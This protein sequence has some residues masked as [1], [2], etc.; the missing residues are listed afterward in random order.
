MVQAEKIAI[1]DIGSNSVRIRISQGEEVFFRKVITTQ[2]ARGK[3][4]GKLDKK[5]V[6]R[7]FD[8]LDRLFEKANECGAKVLAFATAAVRNSCQAKEFC[9][10]F[11]ERYGVAL[12]VISG[13]MEAEMGILGALSGGD[14]CVIDVGGA[15]SEV[16]IAKDGRITYAYS[17]PIG[18]VTLTDQCA[19]DIQKARA[20]I[21]T[22]IAKLP[23]LS[24]ETGQ[25]Y[26]I[27]GTSNNLAFILSKEPVFCREKTSGFIL[28]VSELDWL[29]NDLYEIDEQEI[30]RKYKI[31]DMR[32]KV[33]HSG[34]LILG[35][36]FDFVGAK[37]VIMTEDDNL[38]GYYLAKTK[39]KRYEKQKN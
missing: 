9:Q 37:R 35:S 4:D 18:A 28:N 36:L 3:K 16:V 2:L 39:G 6:E 14:G 29:V 19:K 23:P 32:A 8:G 5:S 25:V 10:S 17:M 38:E 11:F 20:V 13:E 1:I 34:A 31:K 26:S 12:D 30:A 24:V 15:S 27:G 22:E 33:L 21:A 7:T